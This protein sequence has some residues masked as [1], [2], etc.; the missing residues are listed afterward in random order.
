M[1]PIDY[2]VK[3]PDLWEVLGDE[4]EQFFA[5]MEQYKIDCAKALLGL[6]D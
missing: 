2:A 1:P 3:Y 4:I 5:D 6:E